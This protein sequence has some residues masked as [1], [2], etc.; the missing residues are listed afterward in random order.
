MVVLNLGSGK[1]GQAGQIS[2]DLS[3]HAT[4]V[5][6]VDT[7]TFLKA[8]RTNVVDRIVSIHHLEHLGNRREFLEV[9]AEI[10]RVCRVG[11]ELHFELP[12]WSQGVNAANPYHSIHFNEHSFRFFCQDESSDVI[13][14]GALIQTYRFGLVGS[15]NESGFD[16]CVRIDSISYGYFPEFEAMPDE[17]RTKARL[18]QLNIVR[19]FTVRMT[20]VPKT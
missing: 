16:K 5:F 7:L 11:A 13:E 4:S 12:Y 6:H 9:M 19:D 17:M 10:L 14:P 8:V 18:H 2:C 1:T 3:D 15:A 20:V